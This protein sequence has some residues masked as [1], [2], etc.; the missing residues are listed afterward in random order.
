MGGFGQRTA[1][2][3]GS[4]HD[5]PTP[6]L[7]LDLD[8]LERNLRR[9]A[10][11][12][13]RLGVRLRP[14]VKTHK[15]LEICETQAELG[16]PGF[17][18]STLDEARIL[19]QDGRFTDLLWAYPVIPS[20]L[21]QVVETAR[22]GPA[23]SVLRL[24][25]DSAEAVDL[26]ERRVAPK[27]P[28]THVWLEVAAGYA[29]S[30]VDPTS[31]ESL[32]LARR[33]ADSQ[34]LTFNGILSHS[35]HA[36]ARPGRDA[37]LDAAEEERTAMAAFAERLRDAGIEVPRVSV[38]STPAMS[39]AHELPDGL[40]GV[41]EARPGNYCFFDYTQVL[42][43]SCTVE[44]CALT[45]LSTVI[46]SQ[47]GAGAPGDRG[48]GDRSVIDAGAL[49]LSKDAGPSWIDPPGYGRIFREPAFS[50]DSRELRDDACI[51]SLSQEHGVVDARLP[52]GSRLRVLPNHSCL[53]V[54]HFRQYVVVRG[55]RIVD[56]G[57]IWNA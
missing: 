49:Q 45:V 21:D 42:L 32:L 18:V 20:R 47:P 50:A 2:H 1:E 19:M 9:M 54:P 24:V 6:C 57:E 48:E 14:H 17:T 26:L 30:G 11:R 39:V 27:L 29:R 44:E 46:S 28:A 7:V 37:L 12:L 35:G 53:V 38:G 55:D 34:F 23:G 25:V 3:G 22:L 56:R 51:V 41:T 13:R 43:G 16:G 40:E 31:E 5:E 8:V 10:L 4:I 15:C 36:Y 52:Y 33:I